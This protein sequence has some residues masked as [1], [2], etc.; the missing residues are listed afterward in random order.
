MHPYPTQYPVGKV[1]GE[2]SQY[3]TVMRETSFEEYTTI[4]TSLVPSPTQ[5][6]SVGWDEL[7][8]PINVS[9]KANTACM[10]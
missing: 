6:F 9:L 2:R 7:L 8:Y 10:N 4:N 3:Y 5:S 1:Q